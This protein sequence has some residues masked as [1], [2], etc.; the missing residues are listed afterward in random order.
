MKDYAS[1]LRNL[2]TY[3]DSDLEEA[4]PE[5]FA[6]IVDWH[7]K[8]ENLVKPNESFRE[9]I[10]R[11]N[12]GYSNMWYIVRRDNV[13]N[14]SIITTVKNPPKEFCISLYGMGFAPRSPLTCEHAELD[15]VSCLIEAKERHKL[16]VQKIRNGATF[17]EIK[18]N[19]E[20]VW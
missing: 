5:A 11:W 10:H 6:K 18:G 7:E 13:K 8:V 12:N 3:C 4:N 15:F 20:W 16:V 2:L 1:K 19:D 9:R 17:D 14:I